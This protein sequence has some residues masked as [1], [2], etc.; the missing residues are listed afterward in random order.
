MRVIS[1]EPTDNEVVA[2]PTDKESSPA[3]LNRNVNRIG[4]SEMGTEANTL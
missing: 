3:P 2:S 4:E 1:I